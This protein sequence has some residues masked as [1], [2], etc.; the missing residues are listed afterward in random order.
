M[1][2]RSVTVGVSVMLVVTLSSCKQEGSPR[3]SVSEPTF[4][5]VKKKE[6]GCADLF[7]HKG[8][9]DDLEVLWISAEKKKL[10]L[11]EKGSRTFDLAEAPDGLQV[12]IDLW[13][14]APRF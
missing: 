8:T 6:G 9:D 10:K 2:S 1:H 13:E 4:K 14:K 11:P 5:Y 12:A 3:G 7:L